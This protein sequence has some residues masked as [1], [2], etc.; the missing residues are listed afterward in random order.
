[1]KSVAILFTCLLVAAVIAVPNVWQA[2]EPA[3]KG[4]I[5]TPGGCLTVVPPA[6]RT[7]GEPTL[8]P[9]PRVAARPPRTEVIAVTIEVEAPEGM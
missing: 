4:E 1:M 3:A 9:A 5:G 6:A 2:A 8:A 7:Y